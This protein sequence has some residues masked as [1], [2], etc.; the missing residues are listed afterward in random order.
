MLGD[1]ETAP[2][3][4]TPQP[5]AEPAVEEEKPPAPK[6]EDFLIVLKAKGVAQFGN[7]EKTWLKMLTKFRDTFLPAMLSKLNDAHDAEDMSQVRAVGRLWCRQQQHRVV[8]VS[9]MLCV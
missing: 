3:I 6:D 7:N 4:F 5:A 1:N 8:T 9:D 2:T